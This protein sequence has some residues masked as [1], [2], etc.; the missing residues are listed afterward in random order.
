MVITKKKKDELG[1]LIFYYGNT[2]LNVANFD[3][4]KMLKYNVYQNDS[5]EVLAENLRPSLVCA[6]YT[7]DA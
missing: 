5:K 1:D 7:D 2:I 4:K 3:L 6:F